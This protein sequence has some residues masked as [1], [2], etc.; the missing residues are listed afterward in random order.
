MLHCSNI[1]KPNSEH[2]TS[3]KKSTLMFTFRNSAM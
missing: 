3:K 2:C 1:I